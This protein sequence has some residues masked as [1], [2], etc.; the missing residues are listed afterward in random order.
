MSSSDTHLH[1]AY[2]HARQCGISVEALTACGRAF[3]QGQPSAS[4]SDGLKL[5]TA[6]WFNLAELACQFYPPD[7]DAFT[8]LTTQLIDDPSGGLVAWL[9]Q[10][11]RIINWVNPD[12]AQSVRDVI[13]TKLL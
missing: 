8:A 1:T 13:R 10:A 4:W 7:A 5:V 6:F 9:Q 3:G 12:L 11:L 2:A